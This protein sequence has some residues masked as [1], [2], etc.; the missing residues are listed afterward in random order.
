MYTG[1]HEYLAMAWM[2]ISLLHRVE[3]MELQLLP[4][5]AATT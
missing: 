3:S 4:D 5:A 2:D 1:V